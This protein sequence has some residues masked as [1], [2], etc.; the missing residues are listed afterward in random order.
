[1]IDLDRCTN[2]DCPDCYPEAWD[3]PGPELE[4][5]WG[6]RVSVTLLVTLAI[7]SGVVAWAAQ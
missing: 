3:G 2:T 5:A 7:L 4:P 1:M 6:W